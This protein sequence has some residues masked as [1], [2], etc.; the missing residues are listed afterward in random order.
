MSAR[1]CDMVRV[2]VSQYL[3]ESLVGWLSCAVWVGHHD[4]FSEL[5]ILLKR[6]SCA[7]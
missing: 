3:G 1:S 2:L 4:Q 6:H 7:I 5:D